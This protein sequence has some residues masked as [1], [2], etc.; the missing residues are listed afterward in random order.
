VKFNTQKSDRNSMKQMNQRLV[1]HLIQGRGPISR[2]DITRLSGLS[3]ASV[4]GITN[5][6]IESG[7]VYEMG[8]AEELGRAGRR[9]V[10]LRLNPNAGLVVGVKLGVYSISCVLTDLD[11]N[12]LYSTEHLLPPASPLAAPYNPEVTIQT[13]IEVIEGLLAQANVDAGRL[14]GIGVGI[15]GTVDP[16]AGISCLAPHFGWHNISVAEPITTH[17]GIPVY[18][19]ND[20]RALTIAEQWFGAGRE[21]SHFATVVIGYGIGSGLVTNKQLYRGVTGGAGEFG[22]I[23]LQENGPLCSCGNHGCLESLASIPAVFRDLTEALASGEASMLAGQEPLTLDAIAQAA[24]AGDTLTV[25]VLETAG[26]WLGIGIVSLVNMFDPEVLVIYGEAIQ[27]GN[28][29]LSP[30]HSVLKQRAFNGIAKS[31]R[32]LFESGGNEIWAR[33]AACVV[34]NSLFT[35]HEYSQKLPMISSET[36][37]SNVLQSRVTD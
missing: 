7:L 12:V 4:S 23:V 14:L 30:M 16:D 15:N 19:E 17:F 1:L 26:H 6:L 24:A 5:T 37:V 27:L 31:L 3:A 18:L 28:A 25:R 34:L 21:V 20:A 10:L 36:P 22:H 2:R 8:E 13:T 32:V 11:A 9:A 35:S 29:Y 33:G